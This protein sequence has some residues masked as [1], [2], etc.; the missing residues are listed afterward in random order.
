M[1]TNPIGD[2]LAK[3][4]AK[5][6]S[7]E[8][9]LVHLSQVAEGAKWRLHDDIP[10]SRKAGFHRHHQRTSPEGF[11]EIPRQYIVTTHS[12]N[13]NYATYAANSYSAAI[14][15]QEEIKSRQF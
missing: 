12:K 9:A 6:R 1:A 11:P 8:D 14:A 2:F 3:F 15:V 13:R 5:S 4:M 7:E 10:A